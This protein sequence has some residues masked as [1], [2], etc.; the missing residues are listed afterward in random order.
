VLGVIPIILK[1]YKHKILN[2]FDGLILQLFILAMLIPLA[3]N[4]SQQ[5]STATIIIATILPMIF[6]TVQELI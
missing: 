1:P 6:F 2:D 4:V 3:D 5:L